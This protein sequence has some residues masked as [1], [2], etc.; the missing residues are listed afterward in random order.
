M[1][2]LSLAAALIAASAPAEKK[3]ASL[4]RLIDRQTQIAS[5]LTAGK[6]AYDAGDFATAAANW[7]ALLKIE[8]LPADVERAVKPLAA[9]AR[10]RLGGAPPPAEVKL[11]E[12]PQKPPP[13][14]EV[15]ISGTVSGVGSIGP[16]GAVITLHRADGWTPRPRCS[17]GPSCRRRSAS[18]R[19][20]CRSRWG[21]W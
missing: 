7:E 17:P 16:G 4:S 21:A 14:A 3:G 19:T 5:L 13:P 12:V 6:L 15:T 8:G 11:E 18:S 1:R 10:S 2:I 9:E 20:C